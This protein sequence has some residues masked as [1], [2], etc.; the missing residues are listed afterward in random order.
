MQV[1]SSI[2]ARIAFSFLGNILRSALTVITSILLARGLGPTEF[3]QFGFLLASFTA[4][5]QLLDMGSSNAFLTFISKQIRSKLYL[6]YYSGW[7]VIQFLLM[8]L[9]IT[10]LAPDYVIQKIWLGESKG[11][12]L[13]AFIAVFFQQNVW[14]TISRLGESQR[15]TGIVQVLSVGVGIAHLLL[16]GILLY[17]DSVSV[18]LL[19]QIIAIEIVIALAIAVYI[20]PLQ[21]AVATEPLTTILND[22]KVYCKPLIPMT[23]IALIAAF[24]DTWFLQ[25][26]GGSEEQAY[27]AVA[28]QFSVICLIATRSL[29]NILWKEIAEAYANSDLVSVRFLFERSTKGLF[30]FGAMISGFFIPWTGDVIRLTLGEMFLPGMLTMMIMFLYP[31]DQARGQVTGTMLLA[32]EQTQVTFVI[33]ALSSIAGVIMTYFMLAP[34]NASIPGL[35]LG[36]IGLS[37]KMFFIQFI[38]VN[39]SIWWISKKLEMKMDWFYQFIGFGLFISLGYLNYVLFSIPAFLDEHLL[40]RLILAGLAYLFT[41][42]CVVYNF[43]TLF[44]LSQAEMLKAKMFIYSLLRRVT[45]KG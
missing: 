27:Y 24:F 36:S 37:I 25:L 23:W 16:V 6:F 7:L 44:G 32:T 12:I 2:K 40:L 22:Y 29:L 5:T 45:P 11:T 4:L 15:L 1:T 33:G 39:V 26:Y 13:L 41:S 31:V 19:F 38:S 18:S 42:V 14:L 34:A 8:F 35:D 30:Y 3:G 17:L 20:F 10:L 28:S 21:F 43:P 9:F